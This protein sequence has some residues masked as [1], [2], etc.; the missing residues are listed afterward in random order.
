MSFEKLSLKIVESKFTIVG[1]HFF[2]ALCDGEKVVYIACQNE[3]NYRSKKESF[4]TL[5]NGFFDQE[6]LNALNGSTVT[7]EARFDMKKGAYTFAKKIIITPAGETAPVV[8]A[9]EEKAPE[10]ETP[11]VVETPVAKKTTSKKDKPKATHNKCPDCGALI[12]K[13]GICKKCIKKQAAAIK[14]SD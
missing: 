14:A 13:D 1:N 3:M 10:V 12:G 4:K 9:V 6:R 8:K 2:I 5:T 7:L 11:A